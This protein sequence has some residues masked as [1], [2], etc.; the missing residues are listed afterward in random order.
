MSLLSRYILVEVVKVMLLACGV[1]VAVIA[2]GAAIRPLAQNLLGPF[3]LVKYVALASVPMLQF[4][5][6]FAAGFASTIV[7]HRMAS[8]NEIQAMSLSGLSYRRILRPITLLGALLAGV[9]LVLVLAVV[10]QFWII[11]R[12]TLTRDATRLFIATVEDGRAFSSERLQIFADEI[13]E[14]PPPPG[15]EASSRLLMAG[16]VAIERGHDGSLQTEFTAELATVDV[17]RLPEGTFLKPALLDAT[18]YRDADAALIRV[19]RAEPDAVR[20]AGRGFAEPKFM[21]LNQMASALARPARYGPI[22]ERREGLARVLRTASTWRAIDAALDAR[23]GEGA[24]R[25]EDALGRRHYEIRGGRLRGDRIRP[26]SGD[27]IRVTEF[28]EGAATREAT[29]SE[30][31]VVVAEGRVDQRPLVELLFVDPVARPVEAAASDAVPRWPPRLPA[32]HLTVPTEAVTLVE[33]GDL[34]SSYAALIEDVER[35]PGPA[36]ALAEEARRWA[37]AIDDEQRRL[38]RDIL[39]RAT[40]RVALAL[41]APLLLLLGAVLA[42]WRRS[43]TPLEI[44]AIAFVPAII[45]VL[46]ISSGEQMLKGGRLVTGEL[47]AWSGNA[48]LALVVALAWWRMGRH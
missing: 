47:V 19:P 25:L 6:P 1:L 35:G 40:Q 22:A 45:N 27:A 15:G 12:D 7:L 13:R 14:V 30:A 26:R 42:I 29:A 4:A 11:I 46:L 3:D 2:F 34:A 21:T 18:I 8:D 9:M 33:E 41:S 28:V 16:V 23:G 39:A 24:L 31:R 5:L 10:P 32:L 36:S 20:I 48:V 17:Y 43:S 37:K 38:E 44:Y